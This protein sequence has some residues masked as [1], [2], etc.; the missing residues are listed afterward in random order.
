MPKHYGPWTQLRTKIT[1]RNPWI[2]IQEDTVIQPGGAKSIYAFLQK[3]PGVFIVAYDGRGI[4]LLRQY[5]YAIR[6]AIYEIPA[7]VVQGTNYLANAKRE[8]F[9]ETGIRAAQWRKLGTYFTAPGHE[10]TC[11]YAFLATN[12][13]T[14]NIS[15]AR[16]EG[17]ES[18]LD[19]TYV[20]LSKLRQMLRNGEVQCGITLAAL[21][22]FFNHLALTKKRS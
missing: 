1:Y 17:D 3:S 20:P 18:I 2:S 21:A 9:E 8:L 12:L 15:K 10:Q 19:I 22:L 13:N 7:G 5:R 4:Y 11:T 16:Q 14:S 6:Q